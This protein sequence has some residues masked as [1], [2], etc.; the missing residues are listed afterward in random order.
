MAEFLGFSG[1]C[2]GFIAANPVEVAV[3]DAGVAVFAEE[4]ESVGEGFERVGYWGLRYALGVLCRVL[5][6]TYF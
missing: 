3:E 6:W 4:D 2:V 1:F 5:A